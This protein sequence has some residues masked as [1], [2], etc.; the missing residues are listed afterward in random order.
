[1]LHKLLYGL[2]LVELG[3]V[4]ALEHLDKSP[5]CPLVV[6]RVASAYFAAPVVAETN[7]IELFAIAVDIVNGSHLRVLPGLYGILLSRQSIRVI[8][9]WMKHIEALQTLESRVYVT[10]DVAQR[11]THMQSRSRRIGKHI[12]HI[13]FRARSIYFGLV[14]VVFSPIL[15][16]AL[17]YFFIIIFHRKI[18][19]L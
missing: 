15:L 14:G 3:V 8:S 2:S 17:F 4:V 12:E 9:H 16:P 6:F 7:L 11:V 13:E 18:M 19:L 1:M 5:L 10:C